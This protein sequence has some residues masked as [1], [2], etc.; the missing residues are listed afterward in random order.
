MSIDQHDA[1][2]LLEVASKMVAEQYIRP[3]TQVMDSVIISLVSHDLIDP[4]LLC[5]L[6]ARHKMDI[7]ARN[8]DNPAELLLTHYQK[9]AMLTADEAQLTSLKKDLH[10]SLSSSDWIRNYSDVDAS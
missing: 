8:R 7:P 10:N 3:L 4:T 2:A 1:E 9:L 6:I 5:R